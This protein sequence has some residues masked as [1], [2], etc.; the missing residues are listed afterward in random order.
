VNILQLDLQPCRKPWVYSDHTHGSLHLFGAFKSEPF[1]PCHRF[2]ACRKHE[3]LA[4]PLTNVGTPRF[5]T[6]RWRANLFNDMELCF[7]AILYKG[8]CTTNSLRGIPF[9]IVPHELHISSG[10]LLL[11]LI[12]FI[13]GRLYQ[14][15]NWCRNGYD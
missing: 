6:L 8:K 13:A 3:Y 10:T 5:Q 2:D 11:F 12:I 7:Y 9:C 1:F 14:L 15:V 4:I